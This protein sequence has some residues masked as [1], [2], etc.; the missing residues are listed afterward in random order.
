[1]LLCETKPVQAV[2]SVSVDI[3]QSCCSNVSGSRTP[4]FNTA[5]SVAAIVH[6]VALILTSLSSP[7]LS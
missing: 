1:V 6:D 3:A 2:R 4:R 7:L 5:V